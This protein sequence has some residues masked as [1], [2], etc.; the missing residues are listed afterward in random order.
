LQK[1]TLTV[2]SKNTLSK[3]LYKDFKEVI[4]NRYIPFTNYHFAQGMHN[5]NYKNR[6]T[7]EGIYIFKFDDDRRSQKAL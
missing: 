3:N 1:N 5:L 2:E 6:K 7:K 4:K